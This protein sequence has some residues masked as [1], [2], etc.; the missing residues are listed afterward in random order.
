MT[1]PLLWK[2]FD[3][4]LNRIWKRTEFLH[5]THMNWLL[6]IVLVHSGKFAER[7]VQER[8]TFLSGISPHQYSRV[9][10]K[11]GRMINVDVWASTYGIPFGGHA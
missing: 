1:Y 10:L 8:W 5:C 3:R 9:R 11:D 6:K 7:D 2:I 4:D